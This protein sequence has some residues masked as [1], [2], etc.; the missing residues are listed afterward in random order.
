MPAAITAIEYYLPVGRLTNEEL[1]GV[2]PEWSPTKIQNKTGIVERRI[3]A[4]GQYASDLAVAAAVKLFAMG[5]CGPS[6]VDFVILCT[7]T[8]DY[9]LPPSACLVQARLGLRTCVG[10]LDVNLGCSGFV[11][12]L[13]LAKGL[14]ET[15]LC[16]NVLLLL[17][18]TYTKLI[19]PRDRSVRTLF[20]DGAAAVLV[21]AEPPA[22]EG[23][24]IRPEA[25]VFGTDGSG[26]E[27]LIVRASAMHSGGFAEGAVGKAAVYGETPGPQHL[28]MNGAEVF[29]FSLREVPAAVEKLLAECNLTCDD[30]ELF[31]LHQ[32]N[33]YML[34]ALRR[35]MGISR[36]RFAISLAQCGNTVSAS[37]P[38]AMKSAMDEGRLAAGHRVLLVGF[39]VGYSWAASLATVIQ[40]GHSR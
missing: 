9:L 17:A 4:P 25:F 30:I 14:I 24:A 37:I 40:L 7:E 15:G 21:Q 12:C 36:E 38:I 11:Y 3:S 18:D 10:A 33:E 6:D 27:N 5:T 13:A 8:P 19:H 32:A 34:D 1:S 26:A 22:A 2:F 31:V 35:K 16:S 29:A 28:F 20:G 39:G 23:Y